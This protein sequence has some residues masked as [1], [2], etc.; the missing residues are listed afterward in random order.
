MWAD[1][2]QKA[3]VQGRGLVEVRA[4][5]VDLRRNRLTGLQRLQ[6]TALHGP[7]IFALTDIGVQ[8]INDPV[9]VLLIPDRDTEGMRSVLF[10]KVHRRSLRGSLLGHIT[11][12]LR[13]MFVEL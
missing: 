2:S 11:R 4:E 6:D 7:F 9:E 13:L 8:P 1:N 10:L 3:E 5:D 12:F